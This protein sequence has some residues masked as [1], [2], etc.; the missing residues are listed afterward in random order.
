MPF[1]L[2]DSPGLPSMAATTFDGIIDI[3]IDSGIFIVSKHSINIH[4]FASSAANT[5]SASG[6]EMSHGGGDADAVETFGESRR[7]IVYV[8]DGDHHAGR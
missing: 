8:I 5:A 1:F 2:V 3:G 4:F 7:M 6:R